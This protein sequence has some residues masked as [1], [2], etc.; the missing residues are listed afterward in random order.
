M[1]VGPKK[2]MG[3]TIGGMSSTTAQN[4]TFPG[5]SE[6]LQQLADTLR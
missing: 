5:Q 2:K 6:M 1:L 4:V 3:Q